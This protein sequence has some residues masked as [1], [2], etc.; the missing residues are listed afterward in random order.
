[1]AFAET[2]R[3]VIESP[4]LRLAAVVVAIVAVIAI[5]VGLGLFSAIIHSRWF[6]EICVAAA[7]MVLL[8]VIFSGIP[9]FR[10]WRFVNQNSPGY[11][12]GSGESPQESRAK[13]LSAISE[14]K[15]L[16]QVS[17]KGDRLYWLPWYLMLGPSQ[18]GKTAALMAS[19]K[20]SPLTA[21]G[22][23]GTKNFDCWVSNTMLVLD[24]AGRYAIAADAARDRSEW[25]RLLRLVRHYHRRE[26]MSGLIIAV[27]ADQIATEPE[28]KLRELGGKLRERVNESIQE[29]GV[30]PPV[31]ILVTKCDRLEGF[32]EFFGLLP[33]RALSEA[34]GY[35]DDTSAAPGGAAGAAQPSARI[36]TGLRSVY[37]RLHFLRL[38]ILN[39]KTAEQL[40]QHIFCFPEEFRA[41]LAPLGALLEPLAGQD[42][43]YHPTL[44]RGIFFTSARQQGL[45]ISALRRQLEIAAEP[46]SSEAKEATGFF[47]SDLFGTLLPRDRALARP[48][49]WRPKR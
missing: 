22:T 39:G 26:P 37:D 36:E 10:E 8:V 1:M 41:L 24:T 42:V 9:W 49:T 11:R 31:Y 34:V 18:S 4:L 35:M 5:A 40:R 27:A 3:S 19:E 48:A 2:I 21:V 16:P 25:Y 29:L 7:A 17:G 6:L 47:L 23:D 43:R 15:S 45:P 28:E 20:F 33:P 46:M 13:F 38:S 32:R 44:V 12:A 14:L 30:S